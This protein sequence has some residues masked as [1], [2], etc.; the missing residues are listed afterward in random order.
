MLYGCL[1]FAGAR[2]QHKLD[3]EWMRRGCVDARQR[4]VDNSITLAM[5]KYVEYTLIALHLQSHP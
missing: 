4:P 2:S 5:C 3:K 1:Q